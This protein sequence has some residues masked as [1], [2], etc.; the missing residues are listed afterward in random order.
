MEGTVRSRL[1]RR[2]CASRESKDSDVEIQSVEPT[3]QLDMVVHILRLLDSA[4]LLASYNT[5]TIPRHV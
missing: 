4:G 3:D 2:R 1:P 5:N